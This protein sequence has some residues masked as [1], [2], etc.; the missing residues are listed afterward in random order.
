MLDEHTIK[1]A[2]EKKDNN[3]PS[4]EQYHQTET[5][6]FTQGKPSYQQFIEKVQNEEKQAP[7]RA[8][9]IKKK[10]QQKRDQTIAA[11]LAIIYQSSQTD[12]ELAEKLQQLYYS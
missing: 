11:K 6:A 3:E 8:A 1:N 5:Q 4:A 10:Y 7:I 2:T 9:A 12:Q